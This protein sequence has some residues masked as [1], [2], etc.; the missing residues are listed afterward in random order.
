VDISSASIPAVS[1][2]IA[3]IMPACCHQRNEMKPSIPSV[4][5]DLPTVAVKSQTK[6]GRNSFPSTIATH[7][8]LQQRIGRMPLNG[9]V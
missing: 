5:S 3:A 9:I 4:R 1:F 6:G 8:Q 2:V 7:S